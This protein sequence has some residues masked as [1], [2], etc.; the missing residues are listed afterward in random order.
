MQAP[1][2]A[3]DADLDVQ[4]TWLADAR[5]AALKL[6]LSHPGFQ[7]PHAAGRLQG[8]AVDADADAAAA[9]DWSL[10][11]N[12]APADVPAPVAAKQA[13]ASARASA[14]HRSSAQHG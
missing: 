1:V 14:L 2:V 7:H 10:L 11:Q 12:C 8:C 13:L 5:V 9:N 4:R 6:C 3:F